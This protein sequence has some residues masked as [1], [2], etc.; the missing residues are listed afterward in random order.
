MDFSDPLL[1]TVSLLENFPRIRALTHRE[2]KPILVDEFHDLD[3]VQLML[4]TL[5]FPTDLARD[6]FQSKAPHRGAVPSSSLFCI[7]N[8]HQAI[9]SFRGGNPSLFAEHTLIDHFPDR[10]ITPARSELANAS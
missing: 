6:N 4:L 2:H 9:Y 8:P 10:K 5:F 7:G 3:P 1:N